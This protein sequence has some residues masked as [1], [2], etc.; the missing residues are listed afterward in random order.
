MIM[1]NELERIR[2]EGVIPQF[3]P[4]SL[5]LPGEAEIKHVNIGQHTD[6]A[7]PTQEMN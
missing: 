1:N 3:E 6:S 2:K 5:Y 7:E 4:L